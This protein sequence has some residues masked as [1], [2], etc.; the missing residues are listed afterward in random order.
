MFN[1]H[2]G[3]QTIGKIKNDR[4]LGWWQPNTQ[5]VIFHKEAAELTPAC[6]YKYT[7]PRPT[8]QRPGLSSACVSQTL[9]LTF[10]YQSSTALSANASVQR[11][12]GKNWVI[13]TASGASPKAWYTDVYQGDCTSLSPLQKL[14]ILTV[15]ER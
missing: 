7:T 12:R 14:F 4:T 8:G 11:M 6:T 9:L 2:W 15:S 3:A 1:M 13:P 5:T 10:H